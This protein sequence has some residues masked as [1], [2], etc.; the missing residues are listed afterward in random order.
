VRQVILNIV[1]NAAE[2]MGGRGEIDISTSV[3]RKTGIV[4]LSV[5]D[6]GPGVPDEVKS[7]IFEPFFT[8][9]A[10]GT[11][12]GLSIAY[13]IVERHGGEISINSV[14][15]KGTTVCVNLPFQ[16]VLSHA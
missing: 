11:G 6:N 8:T 2:A 13:G 12:L 9:K 1:L 10:T 4:R 15:G 7:R 14:Q 5:S 16:S 3:D